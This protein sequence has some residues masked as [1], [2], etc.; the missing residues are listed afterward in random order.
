MKTKAMI[1]DDQITVCGQPLVVNHNTGMNGT[2]VS[3]FE[4][5]D[6]RITFRF[7]TRNGLQKRLMVPEADQDSLYAR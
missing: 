4:T 6:N 5:L 2:D 3:C 1:N 7:A